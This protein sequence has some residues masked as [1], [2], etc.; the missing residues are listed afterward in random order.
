MKNGA[1]T[2]GLNLQWLIAR[3]DREMDYTDFGE[4]GEIIKANWNAFAGIFTNTNINGVQRVIKKLN[5]ARGPMAHCGPLSE[6]EVV[7]LKLTVRDWY[8]LMA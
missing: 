4:L 3:S 2:D 5:L 1:V 8:K 6:D 7:R